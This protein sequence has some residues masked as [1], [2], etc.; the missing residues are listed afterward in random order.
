MRGNLVLPLKYG[1]TCIIFSWYD[2]RR[3]AKGNPVSSVGN[4]I[5]LCPH[6]G[7][8][9]TYDSMLHGDAQQWVTGNPFNVHYK[10]SFVMRMDTSE[11]QAFKSQCLCVDS[12]AL[13]WP[14]EWE[15]ISKM[16]LVDNSI[17]IRRMPDTTQDNSGVCYQTQPG[18]RNC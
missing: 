15:V 13:L 4:S 9:F 3:P 8:M 14:D 17:S 1:F 2:D 16:F 18:E 5:L 12:I 10:T 7:F 11:V 6:G